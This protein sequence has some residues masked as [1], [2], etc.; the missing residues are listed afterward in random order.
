MCES[1]ILQ[2]P[3]F[4]KPFTVTTDTSDYAIGAVLSQEKDGMDLPVAYM[5]RVLVGHELNY[6]TTEKERLAV[7]E[8][9][10]KPTMTG[11]N[12]YPSRCSHT[13]HPYTKLLNSPL[14]K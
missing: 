4:E 6:S 9:T 5:S 2:Y 10:Q 8:H 7:S 14:L 13:T 3:D 12:F 1:P 11:T